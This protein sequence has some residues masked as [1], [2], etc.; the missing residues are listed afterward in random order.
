MIGAKRLGIIAKVYSRKEGRNRVNENEK[1]G[2]PESYF[3]LKV[4]LPEAPSSNFLAGAS[5]P[6]TL[7]SVRILVQTVPRVAPVPLV[8]RLLSLTP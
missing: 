8:S 2:P 6:L 1:L 4:G 5:A 7:N 3:L